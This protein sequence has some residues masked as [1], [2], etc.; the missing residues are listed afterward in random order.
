MGGD[1]M[2]KVMIFMLIVLLVL[3]VVGVVYSSL[4]NKT[5]TITYRNISTYVN[6]QKKISDAEPFIYNGRTYV[7]LRFISEAL[8]KE[9]TWNETNSRIDINDKSQSSG[10]WKKVIEFKSG[11]SVKTK[12]F[13]IHSKTWKVVFIGQ[14][15][16]TDLGYFHFFA[17]KVG[18]DFSTDS[19]TGTFKDG[20]LNNE[21]YIYE[22]NGNF[23]LDISAANCE[24]AIT[25][26]EQ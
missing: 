10:E 13:T 12:Q 21:T 8:N 20:K 23:Y 16:I 15:T 1:S 25:V 14:E 22:G 3:S 11:D 5:I 7:P 26:Y 17:Y 19:A 9:V 18:E 2:K 4:S 6:D 24:Y